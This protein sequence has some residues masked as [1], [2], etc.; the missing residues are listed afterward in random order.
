MKDPE[1]IVPKLK[2]KQLVSYNGTLCYLSGIT[3]SYIAV[4]NANQLFTDNKTD[5]YVYAIQ[6]LLDMDGKKIINR[7]EKE[8]VIKTNRFGT[9]KLVVTKEKNIEL[10]NKLRDKLGNKIYSGISSFRTFKSNLDNGEE[11]FKSLCIPD[12][13][14][15]IM[16]ILKVL[17][18]NAEMADITLIGGSS[19]SGKARINKNITDVDFKIID[20]SPAGLTQRIRKV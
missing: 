4:H 6:K 19:K 10:Y 14:I 8:Y 5:E 1:I 2:K 7:E 13:S 9:R 16:Q 11:K 15:V 17:K 12:Q 18:C 20:L 3:D